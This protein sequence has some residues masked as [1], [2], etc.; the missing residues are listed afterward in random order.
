MILCG[1]ISS[2]KLGVDDNELTLSI[3]PDGIIDR[4]LEHHFPL[5]IDALVYHLMLEW[6][7]YE[8]RS[9]LF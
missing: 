7:P 2:E 1:L 8:S 5:I 9:S 6:W 4:D 3:H